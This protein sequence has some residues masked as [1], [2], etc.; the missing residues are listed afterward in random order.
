MPHAHLINR[1][2]Q[3]L[4]GASPRQQRAAQHRLHA[5]HIVPQLLLLGNLH[6]GLLLRPAHQLV[7]AL[8]AATQQRPLEELAHI[9]LPHLARPGAQ[10]PAAEI[11]LGMRHLVPALP[12][13][14]L[15]LLLLQ[16][17]GMRS[18][19]LQG[20]P[21]RDVDEQPEGGLDDAPCEQEA[22]ARGGRVLGEAVG[23]VEDAER[24]DEAEGEDAQADEEVLRER[25]A[26]HG[27]GGEN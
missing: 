2:P 18:G 16:Q 19:G 25:V 3:T 9:L 10:E 15:A 27:G 17:R 23:D 7:L 22:A 13:Q 4:G 20:A 26:D 8:P 5:L 21:A 14:R 12:E 6:L 24:G 1:E 11:V